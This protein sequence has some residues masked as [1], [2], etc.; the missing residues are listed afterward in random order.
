M[1]KI[2][3]YLQFMLPGCCAA[4]AAFLLARRRMKGGAFR[5][6]AMLLFWLFTGGMIVITLAPEPGWVYSAVGGAVRMPY[7]NLG[8]LAYRINLIPF[9]QPDNMFHIAG[10]IVMFLPF[11]FFAALLWRGFHWKKALGLGLGIT[12]LIE[13]WQILVGRY[14]DVDDII[15]NTLGVFCGY[16]LWRLLHKFAPGFTKKFQVNE[17]NP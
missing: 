5:K 16:L 13:C 14:F 1:G 11:G 7:F 12:C 4:A 6:T 9:S 8:D 15:L 10:N 17:E 3:C 2:F